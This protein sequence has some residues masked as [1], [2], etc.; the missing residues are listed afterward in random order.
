MKIKTPSITDIKTILKDKD[1]GGFNDK[2]KN[3]RRIKLFS[4][5]SHKKQKRLENELSEMYP[6]YTVAVGN[7]IT[8]HTYFSGGSVRTVIHFRNK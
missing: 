6:D 8:Q 2:R 3:G 5:I 7:F 1:I 4:S